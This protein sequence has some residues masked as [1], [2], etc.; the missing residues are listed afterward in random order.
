[1]STKPS[2][3]G[4]EVV[5][6]NSTSPPAPVTE[7]PVATPGT[8]VRSAASWKKRCLPSASRTASASIV[9]GASASPEAIRV[10][11][12]RSSLPSSRSSPRTPASRVYSVTICSSTSSAIST[13]SARRPLRSICRGHR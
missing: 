8:A 7:S 11:V 2:L 10:A 5:S 9:T 1:M 3:P 13:S 12:L 6:M 4:I